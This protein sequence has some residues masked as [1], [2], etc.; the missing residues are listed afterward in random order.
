MTTRRPLSRA[1]GF[2]FIE[3]LV[4]MGIISVLAGLG[5]VIVGIM[6]RRQPK[7]KTNVTVLKVKAVID[8][9]KQ[10][11]Y[12]Y[13]PSTLAGL[14]K[15]AALPAPKQ[16]ERN[17]VNEGIEA[18]YQ[19]LYVD[20]FPGQPDLNFDAEVSNLDGD[21]LQQ[22]LTSRGLDLSEIKDGY[23]NPLVYFVNTEY[24]KFEQHPPDYVLQ[25]DE[26]A[27][28]KPWRDAG[29]GFVN[30]NGFQIFSMGLDGIPNNDDDIK[31]W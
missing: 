23:G 2:S 15:V 31:G 7:E 19:A 11:F 22:K 9:W 1:A 25:N 28:P 16:V 14:A 8:Q 26:S 3:I 24:V 20:G 30:P 29:G 17:G 21:K 6:Q 10:R 13:P 27:N 12:E 4:V 5:V 18:L